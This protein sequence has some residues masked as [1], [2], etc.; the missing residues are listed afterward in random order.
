VKR[1]KIL[2]LLEAL[3]VSGPAKNTLRFAVDCRDRVEISVATFVRTREKNFTDAI[4]N[5]FVS[6]A[7]NLDIPV[8]IV[9]EKGPYDFSVLGQ[10]RDVIERQ[11][12][13][14]IQTHGIKSHLLVSLLPKRKFRWIAFHHGYTS[15]NFKMR[16]YH[17]FDRWSL[18]RPDLVVTVCEEFA[19]QLVSRGARR[20][21]IFVVP[22][23]VKTDG[24][25]TEVKAT[26]GTSH[27]WKKTPGEWT[28]L[29]VGRLSAEKGHR[30]L[31]D[32]V[33][34][35]VQQSP[36][37]KMKVLIAGKGPADGQLREQVSRNG[38]DQRVQ[39]VGHWPDVSE[40]FSIADLFVLP[41]LSEGSPNVLLES[42]AAKVPIVA[43]N[44]GG[45]P[46]HVSNGETAILVPPAD[47]ASLAAAMTELLSDRSRAA[48]LASAAFDKARLMFSSA[49]YDERILNVYSRLIGN[50]FG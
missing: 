39:L 29:A 14:I 34:R 16:M 30:Y 32:A 50:E 15:E 48:R 17:Q 8:D 21:R 27:K 2:D 5:E 24:N 31:I 9:R 35:M 28:V 40:M 47:S 25:H 12:A 20:D 38:L 26:N 10:L 18:R 13:D 6:V 3:V 1:I 42:M 44:V 33:S 4:P 23:S 11:N 36:E 19:R 49:K 7:R 37:L 46:E 41:S 45:V 43:T 22:N